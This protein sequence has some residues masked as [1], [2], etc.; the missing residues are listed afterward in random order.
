M[1]EASSLQEKPVFQVLGELFV[2]VLLQTPRGQDFT[3]DENPGKESHFGLCIKG[4]GWCK[5]KAKSLFTGPE[6][7]SLQQRHHIKQHR[8]TPDVCALLSFDGC[9]SLFM[10]NSKLRKK[11]IVNLL[12]H[13]MRLDFCSLLGDWISSCLFSIRKSNLLNGTS[14]WTM[15]LEKNMLSLCIRAHGIQYIFKTYKAGFWLSCII[16]RASTEVI[17]IVIS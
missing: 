1:L 15:L 16:Q 8:F 7:D 2:W 13:Q 10:N 14:L 12:Q 17:Q 4:L 5:M 6:D 9:P 11:W 3:P